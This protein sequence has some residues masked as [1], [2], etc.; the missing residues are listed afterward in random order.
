MAYC[1]IIR[2]VNLTP[3]AVRSHPAR[4]R[5]RGQCTELL[6]TDGCQPKHFLVRG[7]LVYSTALALVG[8]GVKIAQR[9]A[10]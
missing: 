7:A 2:L 8:K 5:T 3:S 10:G 4:T 1:S 9:I 6:A